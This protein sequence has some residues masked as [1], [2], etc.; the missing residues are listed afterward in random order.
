MR[1]RQNKFTHQTRMKEGREDTD[2]T[3]TR[4]EHE[5]KREMT[6]TKQDTLRTKPKTGTKKGKTV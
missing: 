3:Q 6:T 1:I 4:H 5:E 2:D